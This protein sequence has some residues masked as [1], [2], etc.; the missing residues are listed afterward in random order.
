MLDELE[1]AALEARRLATEAAHAG[2]IAERGLSHSVA[3]P[4]YQTTVHSF[5]SLEDLDRV[6]TNPEEGWFYYRNA[7]P[8]RTAFE[9]A[10]ARLE[11]AEAAVSAGSGMG[12]IF[13][14]LSAV[15]KSG[16]HIIAD[17]KI[18]GGTFALLTQ[19]LPRFGIETTLVDTADDLAVR[20]ALRPTTRVLFFETITNPTMQVSNLPALADLARKLGLYSFVD[21]TFSTPA[22][23]R[24]L[25][26]GVDIVLHASTKYIG[27][28][29]DALGGIVAGRADIVRAANMA[30]RMMGVTQGPFDA[31]LNVR[32]LKTLPLRMAAHSRN[33]Q[34]VAEWLEKHPAVGQVMY[35][36]LPS[37]PQHELAKKLM[38]DGLYGGM[39]G[40]ELAAGP[41]ALSP[42]VKALK[43]I[44]LVPSLADVI[45]TLS[46]PAITSH[47]SLTP[48]QRAGI[49]V[50][51][52]LLRLSVGIEDPADILEDLEQAFRQL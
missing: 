7:S 14:A 45:T 37:H 47:R 33:A 51:D 22:V 36:G 26:W 42:F 31:W 17:E 50:R 30:G 23:C 10:M 24:P 13:I 15:L 11:G 49:G 5:K 18:Y 29:S 25:Q 44:Q 9:T 19:Q 39:L 34:I 43:E 38:P 1:P 41:Q 35:P 46:H 2:E 21:A 6:Q 48:E 27:G 52:E 8:N 12:A 28:H 3:Q 16:D 40:F 20:T 32:S 4:I